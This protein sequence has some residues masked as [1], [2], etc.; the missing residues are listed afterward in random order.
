M[1]A[2]AILPVN[3]DVSYDSPAALTLRHGGLAVCTGAPQGV[4]LF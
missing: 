4:F 2:S 1:A 3:A